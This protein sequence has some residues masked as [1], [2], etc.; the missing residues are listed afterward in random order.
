MRPAA[1]VAPLT[2]GAAANAP[3]CAV[4]RHTGLHIIVLGESL[5]ETSIVVGLYWFEQMG[6]G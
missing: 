6:E 2:S 5:P 3:P 1:A 4:D